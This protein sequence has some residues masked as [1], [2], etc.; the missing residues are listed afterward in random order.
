[1]CFKVHA[2]SVN[3]HTSDVCVLQLDKKENAP[4]QWI[5]WFSLLSHVFIYTFFTIFT[6]FLL[7]KCFTFFS[8]LNEHSKNKGRD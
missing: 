7:L 8:F 1:M 2:C 6:I 3:T 5:G 4:N